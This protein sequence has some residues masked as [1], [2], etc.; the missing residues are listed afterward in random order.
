MQHVRSW[1]AAVKHDTETPDLWGDL[2]GQAELLASASDEA[3]ENTLFTPDERDGI[4]RRLNEFGEYV[5]VTYSLPEP[6]LVDLDSKL[7][8]LVEA[9]SR[10]GRKDWLLVC[11]GTLFA[12]LLAAA[13]P[14]DVPRHLLQMLLS[15][16]THFFG[17]GLPG[18]G[19]G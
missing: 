3:I 15:G 6:Q 14:P 1:L 18:L 16:I 7:D 19:P 2:L 9:A 4:A 5:K 8:Y 17:H 11:I 12:W 10:L 13:L